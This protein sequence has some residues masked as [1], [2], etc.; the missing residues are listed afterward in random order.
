MAESQN[1]FDFSAYTLIV[2]ESPDWGS[3]AAKLAE[4][5]TLKAGASTREEA[6]Q[7]LHRVF[8][9]RVAY[10]RAAGLGLH[11]P[12]EMSEIAWPS[13]ARV[14]ALAAVARDMFTRVIGVNYD[15]VYISDESC[16]T[17]FGDEEVFWPN[18]EAMYGVRQTDLAPFPYVWQVLE[19]IWDRNDNPNTK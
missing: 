19:A 17:D 13:T 6:V 16:L 4:F 1:F 5:P 7:E 18:L 8:D 10:F 11:G 15:E 9:E 2:T 14:D 12:G 3:F